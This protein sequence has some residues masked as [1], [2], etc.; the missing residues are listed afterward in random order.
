MWRPRTLAVCGSVWQ[1]ELLLLPPPQHLVLR[2]HSPEQR[3]VAVV[4][5]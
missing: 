2:L 5:P 1:P 4:A 3:W